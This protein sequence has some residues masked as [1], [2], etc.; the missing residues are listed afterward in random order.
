M[1]APPTLSLLLGGPRVYGR[2]Y[3]GQ[4]GGLN[5]SEPQSDLLHKSVAGMAVFRGCN[6]KHVFKALSPVP[7]T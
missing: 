1:W 7:G 5:L 3:A 4:A 6:K 2:E